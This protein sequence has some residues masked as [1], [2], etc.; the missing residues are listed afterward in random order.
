[1]AQALSAGPLTV[2]AAYSEARGAG[3]VGKVDV[4]IC[5]GGGECLVLLD[6]FSARK[7]ASERQSAQVAEVTPLEDETAFGSLIRTPFWSPLDHP[8]ES[9]PAAAKPQLLLLGLPEAV[10]E[11]VRRQ[12]GDQV[13][14]L[15]G[16]PGECGAAA[17]RAAAL[18]LFEWLQRRVGSHEGGYLQLFVGQGS[19]DLRLTALDAMLK[20]AMIENGAWRARL[21][22]LDPAMGDQAMIRVIGEQNRYHGNAL[23]R[24]FANGSLYGR[25]WRTLA[26]ESMPQN[27]ATPFRDGGCMRSPVAPAVSA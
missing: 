5:D 11:G 7:T 24:V 25:Q 6:G 10:V 20:T 26:P 16:A 22:V 12:Y 15:P 21:L 4:R 2:I 3:T 8:G 17:Y 18:S 13:T 27:E 9:I 19:D 23:M 1:M 14:V